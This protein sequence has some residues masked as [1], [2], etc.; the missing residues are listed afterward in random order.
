M[1]KDDAQTKVLHQLQ[2]GAKV[3]EAMRTVKR[4]DSTY[5]AW[6]KETDSSFA[7]AV[8]KIR[9]QQNVAVDAERGAVPDFPEFAAKYLRQPLYEHQ[10]R[11]W[12]IIEGG[13][14]RN[15]HHSMRFDQGRPSRVLMNFPPDH[16]KTT[17][18]SINWVTWLIHKD[19][20]IRVA[21][22]SRAKQRAEEMLGAIKARLTDDQYAAMHA[23]L[24]PAGGWKDPDQSWRADRIYVQGKGD[25]EKDPT[26]QALG[27]GSQI[28]GAR[29][30]VI[31]LD[32]VIDDTN[33][34]ELDKQLIWLTNM[35]LS[36]LPDDE[37]DD[38]WE[39]DAA[40]LQ[41]RVPGVPYGTAIVLG[42]RMAPIDMY[43]T[44]RDDFKD[45][46][47]KPVWTYLS[48]PAVLEY[49]E[50]PEDWATL[51]PHILTA[52]GNKR[53]KWDGRA[54][55]RKRA[56]Q[57][58]SARWELVYQQA[59]V[60][61]NATFPAQ[62]IEC[63]INR[64][65]LSGILID[66]VP[67]HR[68]GG[69]DS[70]YVCAGYDPA[71]SGFS[72]FMVLAVDR[73]AQRIWVLDMVNKA[74]MTAGEVQATIKRLTDQYSIRE[75]VIETNAMNRYV[76][77]D[78]EIVNH[79]RARGVRIR[80][81]YTGSNKADPDFG[82]MSLGPLFTSCG[83]PTEAGPWRKTPDTALIELPNPRNSKALS[84]LVS[85]LVTWVPAKPRGQKDDLVMALWFAVI[86]AR[87]A[88]GLGKGRLQTHVSNPWLTKRD[89]G[90]QRVINLAQMREERM[91]S[92]G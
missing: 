57:V 23:D 67:A 79:L 15:L 8:R 29:L 24:A 83:Q 9:T 25:G 55:S 66:G 71:A 74:D 59:D 13:A 62:A 68:V 34:G 80:A 63:S 85:Q 35:V 45:D 17:T 47:G 20:N 52:A 14:P 26:V 49:A 1:S 21:I 44:L 5:K 75:W 64:R 32:D 30:D 50:T 4:T 77:Q 70:L 73:I 7:V 11:A 51:W 89:S 10:L 42:T 39:H 54:M 87:E 92:A 18:F 36:R 72:A 37:V 43:K 84:Q 56:E 31:I 22:I 16:A 6:M 19:P 27:F 91:S 38:S 33:V 82:V 3:S 69:M 12:D 81:H 86:A 76:S 2:T 58:N 53:R 88:M 78:P 61:D 48:Q 41:N 65:R 46:D 28:Y 60:S 90:G 40:E